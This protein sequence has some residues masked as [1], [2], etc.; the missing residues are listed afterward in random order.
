MSGALAV[1]ALTVGVLAGDSV[2]AQTVLDGSLLLA[3]P[4]AV[5][6][7]RDVLGGATGRALI[8]VLGRTG[9]LLLAWSLLT[10]VGAALTAVT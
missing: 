2:A 9:L 10:A 3:V 1:G 4:L 8:P 5:F 7:A 6:L